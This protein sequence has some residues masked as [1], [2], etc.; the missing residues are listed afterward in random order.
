MNF[1]INLLSNKR[2]KIVY[3]FIF[4]IVN[5]CIKITKYISITIKYDSAELTK[6]FFS[7][8]VFKFNMFNDIVNNKKSIFINVF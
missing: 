8:I 7:E 3:N 4:V 6:I 1:I 5:R 2:K